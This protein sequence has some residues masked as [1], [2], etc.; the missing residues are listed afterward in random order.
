MEIINEKIVAKSRE[1]DKILFKDD[2]VQ[3]LPAKELKKL[4]PLLVRAWCHIRAVYLLPSQELI[5]WVK[6]HLD[7]DFKTIEIGAGNGCLGRALGIP[8]YDNFMQ[9]DMIDVVFTM[10][11]TGQPPVQY[12]KDVIKRP[13]NDIVRELGPVDVVGAWI[14][15]V[16]KESEHERG[17]NTYGPDEEEILE[18]ARRYIMIGDEKVHENKRILR[19]PHKS[20][21]LEGLAFG[22][23]K[24]PR[25]WIW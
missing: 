10:T 12:G 9:R 5:A 4:D 22:R 21:S 16:Y 6:G 1:L 3:V 18:Y 13:A 2:Q 14:T 23:G 20:F 19:H 11:I 25:A 15:H 17:G 7:D 24:S 8:M